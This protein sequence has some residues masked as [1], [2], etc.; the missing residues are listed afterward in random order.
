MTRRRWAPVGRGIAGGTCW[1]LGVG[2]AL[3]AVYVMA[4]WAFNADGGGS[5][6]ESGS[7]I[8]IAGLVLGVVGT[9]LL[10]S[11]SG[12]AAGTVVAAGRGCGGPGSAISPVSARLRGGAAAAA[13]AVVAVVLGVLLEDLAL[14]F[15][16]FVLATGLTWWQAPR[17]VS[18]SAP[19]TPEQLSA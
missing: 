11:L 6:A 7:P 12:G 16:G 3:V 8:I 2:V 1:G 13:G 18:P 14:S 4:W 9:T 10:G 17:L 5:D 15:A 19:W